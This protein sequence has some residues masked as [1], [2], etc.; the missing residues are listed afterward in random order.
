[1]QQGPVILQGGRGWP[2]SNAASTIVK[3]SHDDDYGQ[4]VELKVSK[5]LALLLVVRLLLGSD[6]TPRAWAQG[7]ASPSEEDP[8]ASFSDNVA[9]SWG[10]DQTFSLT[11]EQVKGLNKEDMVKIWK[12]CN[13]SPILPGQKDGQNQDLCQAFRLLEGCCKQTNPSEMRWL[14]DSN[15]MLMAWLLRTGVCAAANNDGRQV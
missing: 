9:L 13:Q 4:H 12:V 11:P 3:F 7:V 8:S 14:R 5:Q 2:L 15:H 6:T 10:G 1:M